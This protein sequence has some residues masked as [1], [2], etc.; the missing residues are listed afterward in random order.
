MRVSSPSRTAESST[1]SSEALLEEVISSSIAPR[2]VDE[3][4][5]R[6]AR[7]FMTPFLWLIFSSS[8]GYEYDVFISPL[9]RVRQEF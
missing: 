2:I 4:N 3:A 8:P 5:I 1:E 9:R 7:R 6:N